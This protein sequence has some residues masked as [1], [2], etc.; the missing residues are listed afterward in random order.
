LPDEKIGSSDV[1][2]I[3][4][5]PR[6][7]AKSD[8]EAVV[9]YVRKGDYIPLKVKFFGK[10]GKLEK[11]MFVEKLDKTSDGQTYAK[12]MTLR[13]DGGGFTTITIEALETGTEIPDSVFSKEQ[14]GK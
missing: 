11:T 5:K 1:W 6:A 4:S 13:P 12:Q 2:V 8:Y 3:K 10:G 14:L 7:G 9:V